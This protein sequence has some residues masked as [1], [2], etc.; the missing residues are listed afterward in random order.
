MDDFSSGKAKESRTL[1]NYNITR[2]S[3]CQIGLAI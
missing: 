3:I 1:C 2:T